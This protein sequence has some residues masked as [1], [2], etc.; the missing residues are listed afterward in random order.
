MY[1]ICS[2]RL[3]PVTGSVTAAAVIVELPFQ[4]FWMVSVVADCAVMALKT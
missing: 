4:S 3:A 1:T 2:P